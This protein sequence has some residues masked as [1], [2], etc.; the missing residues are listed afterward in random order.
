MVQYYYR[1]GSRNSVITGPFGSIE[2]A[3]MAAI[4]AGLKV[5]DLNFMMKDGPNLVKIV[6]ANEMLQRT[7]KVGA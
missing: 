1:D 7:A 2:E 5:R 3:R 4:V 6:A